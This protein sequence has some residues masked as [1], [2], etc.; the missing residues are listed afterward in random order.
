MKVPKNRTIYIGKKKYMEGDEIPAALAAKFPKLFPN[1]DDDKDKTKQNTN[2]KET[3][4]KKGVSN[5]KESL[6][7]TEVSE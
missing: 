2:K 6:Y 4:Y 3:S 7:E 1:F 5:K